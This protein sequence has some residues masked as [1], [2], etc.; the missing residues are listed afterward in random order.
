MARASVKDK[1][2]KIGKQTIDTILI[3]TVIPFSYIYGK[4]TNPNFDSEKIIDFMRTIKA[5]DNRETR[6]FAEID[7]I[8]CNNALDTQAMLNLKKN[9]CDRKRCLDCNIGFQ[10]MKE[11]NKV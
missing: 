8:K 5:E 7:K 9:Y 1:E 2:T 4:T 3:N 6:T 11:I 10:I